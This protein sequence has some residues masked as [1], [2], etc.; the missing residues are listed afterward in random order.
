MY[1]CCSWI[2]C[3]PWR[4]CQTDGNRA[5]DRACTIDEIRAAGYPAR[6]AHPDEL[7]VSALTLIDRAARPDEA[8]VGAPTLEDKAGKRKAKKERQR[9]ARAQAAAR[10]APHPPARPRVGARAPQMPP[11]VHHRPPPPTPLRAAVLG[12]LPSNC[13][14][15]FS[16]AAQHLQSC[17]PQDRS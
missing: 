8:P 9:S 11:A 4:P 7:P 12:P 13:P 1:V 3:S 2:S 17:Q 16:T 10:E 15:L 5:G 14:A 6:A